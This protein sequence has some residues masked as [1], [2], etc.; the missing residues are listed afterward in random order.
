MSEHEIAKAMGEVLEI[1][2]IKDFMEAIQEELQ[3][4]RKFRREYL[5]KLDDIIFY[6]KEKQEKGEDVFGDR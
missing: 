5:S 4:R 3:D 6:L 2:A 1:R